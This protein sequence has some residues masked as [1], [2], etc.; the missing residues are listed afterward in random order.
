MV[1]KVRGKLFLATKEKGVYYEDMDR[2]MK[3]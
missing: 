1:N 3:I 2:D